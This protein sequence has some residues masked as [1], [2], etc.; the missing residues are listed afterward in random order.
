MDKALA[1]RL[2]E[3]SQQRYAEH[4]FAGALQTLQLL[5]AAYPDDK[6][7]MYACA[8]CLTA[9][10]DLDEARILCRRCLERHDSPRVRELLDRLETLDDAGWDLVEVDVGLDFERSSAFDVPE[11]TREISGSHKR[12]A[13]ALLLGTISIAGAWFIGGQL[14]RPVAEVAPF[15]QA[16]IRGR[17]EVRRQELVEVARAPSLRPGEVIPELVWKRTAI[18]G[19][20]DWK[21][22]IYERVPCP[23]AFYETREGE[24]KARTIDVY[25]PM[26]Y[27][28]RPD[29]LFSALAISMPAKYSG[30]RGLEKWAER[31][32]VI[33]VAINTSSN[34]SRRQ[35]WFAQ[36]AAISTVSTSM[37]VDGRLGFAIGVSGGAAASWEMICRYPDNF[38]GVVMIAMS[39]GHNGCMIPGHVRVGYIHGRTDFNNSGIARIIPQL[40]AAGYKVKEQVVPGGHVEG[41][42][43]ARENMLT[44]ML[45]DVRR[46]Y[47]VMTLSDLV[48]QP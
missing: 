40:R 21:P 12:T 9:L 7:I 25:V 45:N 10:G 19:L 30:F 16:E 14:T 17:L 36:N 33:L 18:Q 48:P 29:E 13:V 32:D 22:G 4:N 43:R 35:N 5:E 41:P 11:A 42:L 20:P 8:R 47:S 15:S 46:E 23:G 26:A 39:R 24:V 3:R 31:N 34:G 37:R 2:F 27:Q 44:W 38:V 28:E 6:N 1:K